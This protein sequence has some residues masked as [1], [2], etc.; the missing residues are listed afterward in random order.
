MD[1]NYVMAFSCNFYRKSSEFDIPIVKVTNKMQLYMLIYYSKS[2]LH[3][4]GD[5]L[6]HQQEYLTVFTVSGSIHPGCC[7]LVSWMS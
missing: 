4:S 3:V 6:A 1:H 5:I 2:A 7:R